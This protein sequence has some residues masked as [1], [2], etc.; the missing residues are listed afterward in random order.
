LYGTPIPI[1]K[2]S[3]MEIDRN[4]WEIKGE[5]FHRPIKTDRENVIATAK[6]FL[7]APYLWGGKSPFGLDCSGLTQTVFNMNGITLPRDAYLQ[8]LEGETVNL[9]E[10]ALPGDLLFFDN[11]EG[12]IIHV[13][14]LAH[15]NTI[16]HSSGHVRIDPV[17]HYG[18][19]NK[20]A[21]SY[22]HKLRIIKRI[23]K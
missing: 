16:I 14:I 20:E 17:D 15:D 10:E 7:N 4:M 21:Q 1:N 3:M 11:Q 19:Y 23:I 6:V 9:I 8:A 18:I 12:R 5:V 2:K 13:G 22:S